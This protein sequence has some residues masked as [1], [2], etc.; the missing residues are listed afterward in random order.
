MDQHDNNEQGSPVNPR[1]QVG[2]PRKPVSNGRVG[3]PFKNGRGS[4]EVGGLRAPKT[5]VV[6]PATTVRTRLRTGNLEP[7]DYR[8]DPGD[9]GTSRGRRGRPRGRP[10]LRRQQEDESDDDDHVQRRP[11]RP[12]Q[13]EYERDN[14]DYIRRRPGRPRQQKDEREDDNDRIRR[15]PGRP[16]P[17]EDERDDD[18][19]PFAD[20]DSSIRYVRRRPRQHKDESDDD[21]DYVRYRPGRHRLLRQ[22]EDESD[23]DENPSTSGGESEHESDSQPL[24]IEMQDDENY[25]PILISSDSN[26][27][28]GSIDLGSPPETRKKGSVKGIPNSGLDGSSRRPWK[29]QALLVGSLG[30]SSGE[31]SHP[32]DVEEQP[33]VSP[34]DELTLTQL[35]IRDIFPYSYAYLDDED[36]RGS[37]WS[38]YMEDEFNQLWVQDDQND[39]FKQGQQAILDELELWKMMLIR[40]HRI[41]PHLFTYGLKLGNDCYEAPGSLML[42]SKASCMLLR[43]CAHPIWGADL[44]SLRYVLQTAVLTSVR[45]H[46]EPF[47]AQPDTTDLEYNL[48]DQPNNEKEILFGTIHYALWTKNKPDRNPEIKKLIDQFDGGIRFN[49]DAG[50]LEKSLFILTT[51]VMGDLIQVLNQFDRGIYTSTT[52]QHVERFRRFYGHILDRVEPRDYEQLR[53]VK[54]SLELCE[55]RDIEI[56]KAMR[57]SIN[58]HHFLYD[59]PQTSTRHL[60]KVPL[61]H[62]HADMD[63]RAIPVLR[64]ELIDPK[65]A[66]LQKLDRVNQNRAEA[67]DDFTAMLFKEVLEDDEPDPANESIR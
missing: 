16:R 45:V 62:H 13:N 60:Y 40:Y 42:S 17:N 52:E 47:G 51:S 3:R 12:R 67:L 64:G 50:D 25:G 33:T 65:R 26:S 37:Y 11:G 36:L 27:N 39:R 5:K 2:R 15:R 22:L 43:I 9:Q 66:T 35:Q 30:Q 1:G 49:R 44:D 31:S 38:E 4:Y 14:A 32:K 20:S 41:P 54:W 8:T 61:Y 29:S 57:S 56:R 19:D 21:D 6:Q 34:N 7:K 10:R 46:S 24:D 63:Q 18:D 55:L 28:I 58:D 53:D 59:V 48:R 23:D